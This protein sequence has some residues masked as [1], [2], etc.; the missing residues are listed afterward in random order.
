MPRKVFTAGEVLAAADVNS[1]LM[2]QS[3][4]TFGSAT[5]RDAAIDTPVEGMVAYLED[6]N[7]VSLYS[8]SEWKDS[9]GVTGGVLQVV[10]ETANTQVSSSS[11]TKVDTTLSATITPKSLTS[12]IFVFISHNGVVKSAGNAGNALVLE[13]VY[14][15]LSVLNI[16]DNLGF[17]NSAVTHQHAFSS[18]SAYT[19]NSLTAQTFKTQFSNRI[20]ATSVTINAGSTEARMTLMEVAN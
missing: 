5:A 4:M 3:V 16:G 20:T 6:S 13:L 7:L 2:D 14:P 17:T 18:H 11:T 15:D 8:G 9:L 1:F 10:T 19:H 12:K